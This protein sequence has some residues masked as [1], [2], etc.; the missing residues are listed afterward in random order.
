MANGQWLNDMNELKNKVALVTG[1]SRGIGR[2]IA[3]ELARLD[4]AVGLAPAEIDRLFVRPDKRRNFAP[5]WSGGAVDSIVESP[6][7]AAACVEGFGF[8]A[9]DVTDHGGAGVSGG[10]WERGGAWMPAQHLLQW[11]W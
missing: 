11:R 9:A 10:V 3:L 5:I 7:E 4:Y 1:A 6:A 8:A 2:G